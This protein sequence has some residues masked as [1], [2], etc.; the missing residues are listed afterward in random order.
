[1]NL[2]EIISKIRIYKLLTYRTKRRK[3]NKIKI[4]KTLTII[5]KSE[6]NDYNNKVTKVIVIN[7]SGFTI[8]IKNGFIKWFYHS[9]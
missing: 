8:P 6:Y 5:I 3:K 4:K 7:K 9:N 2:K 1:M